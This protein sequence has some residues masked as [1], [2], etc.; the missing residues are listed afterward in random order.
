MGTVPS[1]PAAYPLPA[2]Y[3]Q[4]SFAGLAGSVQGFQEVR[5]IGSELDTEEVTEGGENRFVHRLPK[6]TKHPL[7]EFRRGIAPLNSPLIKWCQSVLESDFNS[8]ILTQEINVH[9]LDE[10]G[11]P[12][13]G[14]SFANAYP[15]K[16]EID[17]LKSAKNDVAIETIVLSYTDCKRLK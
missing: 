13:R 2:F 7:L 15:V 16:W 12:V 14:W 17:G 5:G 6:A 1:N 4:V 10:N 8:P 3:F 9:L 11:N